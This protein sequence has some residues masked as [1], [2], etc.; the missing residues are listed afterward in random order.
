MRTS[1]GRAIGAPVRIFRSRWIAP[2]LERLQPDP[3]DAIRPYRS[4]EL[5]AFGPLAETT[6]EQEEYAT[7]AGPPQRKRECR[8]RRRVQPLDIVDPH[9]HGALRGE[10]LESVPGSDSNGA[11]IDSVTGILQ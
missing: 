9:E 3:L 6:R 1:V 2:R 7:A 10:H 8:G 5:P 11:W 4:L